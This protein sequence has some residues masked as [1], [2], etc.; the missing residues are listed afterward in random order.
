MYIL[1]LETSTSAAKALLYHPEKGVVDV[2]TVP[3]PQTISSG[4]MQDTDAV[5]HLTLEA[6]KQVAAGKDIAG[7]SVGGIWH[8]IAIC[9]SDGTPALPTYTWTFT[10][11][12]QL[13]RDIR[14]DTNLSAQ[15]YARTGCMPNVTYQ[16]YTLRYLN[17]QGVDLTD[18][19]LMSQASY[20]FLHMTNTRMETPC[21]LSGMGLLNLH[22]RS[23][24]TE[25]LA[26]AGVS[27]AQFAPLGTYQNAMPLNLA[28]A[29]LLGIKAGIPVVPPH[30][31][32]ALNQLGNGAIA[33]ALMTFS[34]GTSAAIRLTTPT[35]ILSNPPATWCY[36][37]AEDYMSGAA[38]AGACNCINWFK[39]CM[40]RNQYSYAQLEKTLLDT[41]IAP[42]HS[43]VFLPF[44]FGERCPGWQDERRGGFSHLNAD[45]DI[46]AMYA[47]VCEGILFN[48][49]H[50]FEILTALSGTPEKIMMSGGILNSQKWTQ[51]A[52]DIFHMPITISTEAQ[53]SM[54]GGAVLGM[55]VAGMLNNLSDFVDPSPSIVYPREGLSQYYREKFLNYLHY[56]QQNS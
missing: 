26:F 12:S 33:P 19:L 38:T 39:E 45:T 28:C 6:G 3:Y 4:G 37:G 7:I 44:L 43:P 18:K 30:A 11:T 20:N 53:A 2:C 22:T 51:L 42:N 31:D 21:I 49:Y 52:A 34:V 8:S 29:K 48:I 1:A 41:E 5:F 56:Y 40:L 16:P 14:T 23:Y 46:P 54:I 36:M 15:I 32:G 25:T 24:D 47:A 9:N 55:H 35:P 10:G 17:S 27:E 13:C 50:C